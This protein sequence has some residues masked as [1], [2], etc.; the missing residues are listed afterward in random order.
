VEPVKESAFAGYVAEMARDR[1]KGC[2]RYLTVVCDFAHSPAGTWSVIKRSMKKA[3]AQCSFLLASPE[4]G[5]S[6]RSSG[7]QRRFSSGEF[8]FREDQDNVGVFFL[9]TGKILMSVR[10]LPKLNRLLS[11]GSV[12][13]LP[14]SFTGH[15]YSLK[16]QAI[17][18]CDLVHV[19]QAA[20][21]DLMRERSDLCRECTEM[22]GREVTFIQA[23]L[24]ERR[25]VAGSKKLLGQRL[26]VG[27]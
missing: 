27:S 22:L 2:R 4:L 15:P 20:F 26:A 1:D 13:G 3:G 12:L 17:A 19:E 16:A 21:L 18:E 11:A 8:L 14:S 23:A 24:A 7:S 9:L 10:G 25:K 6:L 5:G